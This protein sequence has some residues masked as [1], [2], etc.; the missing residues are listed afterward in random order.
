MDDSAFSVAAHGLLGKAN[1]LETFVVEESKYVV[2]KYKW[3]YL[4]KL[5]T[6]FV[7]LAFMATGW[8]IIF[9]DQLAGAYAPQTLFVQFDDD[10]RPDLGAYSGHFA[11]KIL[12]RIIDSQRLRYEAERG[13]GFIGY[14]RE[15][16][17]WTFVED[18]DDSCRNIVAKSQRT[19]A[20]DV[21]ETTAGGW[22]VTGEANDKTNFYPLKEFQLLLGCDGD[23]TC[24]GKGRGR[25]EENEKCSCGPGFY[26]ARCQYE[27]ES[28]CESIE[29]SEEGSSL[30]ASRE[31]ASTFTLL[32]DGNGDMLKLYDHP[33]Y[34]AGARNGGGL[35]VIIFIGLRWTLFF[36][37]D[38]FPDLVDH[39]EA[40][41]AAYLLNREFGGQESVGFVGVVSGDTKSGTAGNR[42]P[43]HGAYHLKGLEFV[44]S[45]VAFNTPEDISTP[46]GVNWFTA[47][48]RGDVW[49]IAGTSD[50][51]LLCGICSAANPCQNNNI[52]GDDGR[53]VCQNG[54][55]GTLCQHTPLN[56]GH[57]DTAFSKLFSD[58]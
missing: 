58:D 43:F 29:I 25:C 12:P 11:L 32:R 33:V 52:C 13:H 38:G 41:L 28:T 20:F 3:H 44:S 14:C 42:Y 35:D 19:P 50:A 27:I 51:V 49:E 5:T 10:L 9:S 57:C 45:A 4:G 46:V 17:A 7:T 55:L 8:G 6:L 56:N 1:R 54:A 21:T 16:N 23:D 48:A 34:V 30:Q 22:T 31:Y 47:R 40:G 2:V 18:G 15:E 36:S 53:C 24:G 39:S 37:R 26:G